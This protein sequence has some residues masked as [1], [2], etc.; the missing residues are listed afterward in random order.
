MKF[1][2][3]GGLLL[4]TW[5][6][7]NIEICENI[8]TENA[9]IFGARTEEVIALR[10]SGPAMIDERL[11]DVIR[12]VQE[13]KF[14]PSDQFSQLVDPLMSGNDWYCLAHDFPLYIDCLEEVDAAWCD[15]SGWA[16]RCAR[17][18]SGM[19][20]FSSDRSIQEYA[21]HIWHLSPYKL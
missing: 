3:N 15:K 11:Y 13:G 4:G 9:F 17:S 18:I 8:G 21:K 10:K 5:D 14:G 19:G 1:V 20:F 12:A 6:G 7:A 16:E 2:L